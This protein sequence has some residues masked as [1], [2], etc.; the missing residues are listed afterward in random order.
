[1]CGFL[2]AEGGI[3]YF[4][5]KENT[6]TRKRNAVGMFLNERRKI[7]FVNTIEKLYS[8][9]LPSVGKSFLRILWVPIRMDNG[10]FMRGKYVA[11][12]IVEKGAKDQLYSYE[13]KVGQ[14]IN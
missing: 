14:A 5:I 8:S 12:V 13:Q 4:G 2:N 1:M 9:I 3:I 7:E 11:K 10:E 6:N